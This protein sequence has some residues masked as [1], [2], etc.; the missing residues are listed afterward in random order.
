MRSEGGLPALAGL[1]RSK[2]G[3]L[4]TALRAACDNADHGRIHHIYVAIAPPKHLAFSSSGPQV[5]ARCKDPGRME[6]GGARE[7]AMALR[8]FLSSTSRS[9]GLLRYD[10]APAAMPSIML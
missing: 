6:G 10:R 2:G 3:T 1:S 4:G 5:F 7:P 8:S 9:T